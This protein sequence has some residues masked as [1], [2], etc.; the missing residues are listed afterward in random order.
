M[1]ENTNGGMC[2]RE[3]IDNH[4]NFTILEVTYGSR[5]SCYGRLQHLNYP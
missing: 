5:W 2:D 3:I 1:N 4:V